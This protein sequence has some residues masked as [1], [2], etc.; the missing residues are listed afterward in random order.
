M[1]NGLALSGKR[2]RETGMENKKERGLYVVISGPSGSGKST[3]IQHLL[4]AV[5]GLTKSV[6]VTT[7]NPRAGEVEGVD[8]YFKTLHEYQQMIADGAFLETAEVYTNFYGTPKNKII[9]I[10]E[11]G[12]DVIGELDTIGAAQV[13]K[14]YPKSVRIFLIP[15]SFKIL[16][17]RLKGRGTEDAVSLKRRMA[18]AQ[19]E[20]ATYKNYDYLVYNDDLDKARDDIISIIAAEKNR[21]LRRECKIK[22]MLSDSPEKRK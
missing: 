18:A 21:I 2:G 15:S 7:R 13:K 10:T 9:E 16:H 19:K 11:S 8:Y 4:K 6:S 12:A 1:N 5:P 20:L 14:S 3:V 17:D 22:V